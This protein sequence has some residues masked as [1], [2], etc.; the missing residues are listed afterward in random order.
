MSAHT[1]SKTITEFCVCWHKA[2][3]ACWWEVDICVPSCGCEGNPEAINK[4]HGETTCIGNERL[5]SWWQNRSVHCWWIISWLCEKNVILEFWNIT[6]K[7][8]EL[9]KGY[10]WLARREK[11]GKH[12]HICHCAS[13]DFWS[14]T[15]ST[16]STCFIWSFLL[17]GLGLNPLAVLHK[18]VLTRTW[19]IVFQL[20]VSTYE[21]LWRDTTYSS[22]HT[23][24]TSDTVGENILK[25]RE[26]WKKC[27]TCNKSLRVHQSIST[28]SWWP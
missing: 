15:W 18:H 23:V 10:S 14:S 27:H 9:V 1:N 11:M 26:E 7:S 25:A 24:N 5:D 20:K 2:Y 16:T 28:H 13:W 12:M 17:Q 19:L 3:T 8:E 21:P 4:V 6:N 22:I